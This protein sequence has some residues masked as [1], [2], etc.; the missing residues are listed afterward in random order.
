MR[1]C[2]I[3]ALIALGAYAKPPKDVDQKFQ[4]LGDRTKDVKARWKEYNRKKHPGMPRTKLAKIPEHIKNRTHHKLTGVKSVL[5]VS[6]LGGCGQ[7]Q[8]LGLKKTPQVAK[9]WKLGSVPLHIT[10]A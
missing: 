3:L 6:F 8:K 1:A 5:P 2:T 4:D 10:L 7:K 9:F